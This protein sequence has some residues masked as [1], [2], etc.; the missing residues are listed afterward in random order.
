LFGKA[1]PVMLAWFWNGDYRALCTS[2][3]KYN[4]GTAPGAVGMMSKKRL[5]RAAGILGVPCELH[6]RRPTQEIHKRAPPPQR[7]E[8]LVRPVPRRIL[9]VM[10]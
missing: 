9:H 5:P 3:K 1:H 2:T 8:R 6:S 4:R 10:L 7:Q